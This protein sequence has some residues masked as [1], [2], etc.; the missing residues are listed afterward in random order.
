M[1]KLL[2]AVL[3]VLLL[4]TMLGTS[5][6]A[7]AAS[8]ASASVYVTIADAKGELA[9]TRKAVTVKDFD[10]DGTLTVSDALYAA[11]EAAFEGGAAAG[12]ATAQSD[13]GLSLTKLWGTENGGSYGYAV[14]HTMANSLADPVKDGDTVD[15]Y[16]YTDLTAWSD[17]YCYFDVDSASVGFGGTLSLTLMSA[18]FDPETYAPVT[19]P[20]AGAVITVNGK[21]SEAVTDSEGHATITLNT[22][23]ECIISAKSDSVTLV[24]PCCVVSV[25]SDASAKVYVTIADA[26]GALALAREEV[27]VKDFDADGA[28][29]V[30][31]ALYAAHEAAFEGGAAAGYAAAQS[32]WGLSLTKLWGVENGGSYGYYVNNSASWSLADPVK[33]G[34]LVAAFVYTDLT[35]WSDTYCYFDADLAEV[36]LGDELNVK[37]MRVGYDENGATVVLPVEG[38][39]LLLGGKATGVFTDAEG[40]AT[41]VCDTV[42]EFVLSAHSSTMTLVPPV[43]KLTVIGS[44][45]SCAPTESVS[46]DADITPSAPQTGDGLTGALILAVLSVVAISGVAVSRKRIDD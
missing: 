3:C 6:A 18:G 45:E 24:P 44:G 42:G 15:A 43:L 25:A 30:N 8:D 38:A 13:W 12:Y 21:S 46:G 37:L 14:N 23:G 5:V 28:L 9:L 4:A 17:K 29:T 26:D 2:S 39:E 10:S 33:D 36:K 32:D 20:V 27:T 31:D 1:K 40:R 22:A 7:D 41:L 34:D 19:L 16:V 35:A 11:H